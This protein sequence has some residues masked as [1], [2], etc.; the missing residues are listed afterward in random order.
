MAS[1]LLSLQLGGKWF[2]NS[3]YCKREIILLF[4]NK[5]LLFINNN[6]NNNSKHLQV[7]HCYEGPN[8]STGRT[9]QI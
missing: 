2:S 6:N 9:E 3:I 1:V 7:R 5:W 4:I 8:V